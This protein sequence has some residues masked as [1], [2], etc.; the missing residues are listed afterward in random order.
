MSE[1]ICGAS[2]AHHGLLGSVDRLSLYEVDLPPEVPAEH[3]ASLTSCVTGELHIENV[4]V[5]ADAAVCGF[6]LVS[7]LRS[8]NCQ[9]LTFRSH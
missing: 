7:I 3:L 6:Y 5:N 8:L 1:L 9:L 4:I 2:L